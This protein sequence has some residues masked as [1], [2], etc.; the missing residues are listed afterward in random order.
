MARWPAGFAIKSFL[1]SIIAFNS[2][3]GMACAAR[4]WVTPSRGP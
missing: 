2:P 3:R 4:V 1:T